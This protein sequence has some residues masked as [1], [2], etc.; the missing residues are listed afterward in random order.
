[1]ERLE[2]LVVHV[3]EAIRLSQTG[4]VARLRL[5]L[6]LLD[7]AAELMLHREISYIFEFESSPNSLQFLEAQD[8][9]GALSAEMQSHLDY[10]RKRSVTARRRRE[11]DR[12]FDAKADFL[13][14]LGLL[15]PARVRV[16]RK[17]HKYR[18]EAYHRD[19]LRIG[20]L[21]SA[22]SIYTYIICMMMQDIP[23]HYIGIPSELPP[24]VQQYLDPGEWPS[25]DLQSK[26][27]QLLLKRAHLSGEG[28][29]G[30]VLSEHLTD[31][32]AELD[33]LLEFIADWL[34]EIRTDGPWAID[35]VLNLV[36][37][38]NRLAAFGSRE[39]V[40]ATRVDVTRLDI[41][42]WLLSAEQ[43]AGERNQ[44]AAFAAFADIEDG[45]E[46]IED[47][48]KK[49]ASAVEA[50]INLQIDIARGK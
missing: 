12:N 3:E 19:H 37:I 28:D 42:A 45:F 38:E 23:V 22:V 46:V 30:N 18:N 27:S 5:A 21:T 39:Q 32:L 1:V 9:Q 10:L 40:R 35:D 15:E 41:Q 29:L 7:S 36:Q 43:I 20:T 49:S 31:R 14:S 13:L 34:D 50:E 2:R 44:V 48:I 26:I 47:Q 24:S 8:A 25:F 4:E 6:L 11:I 33:E 17:L 16:L